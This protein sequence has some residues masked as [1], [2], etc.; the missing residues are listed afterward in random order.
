MSNNCGI[1]Q[2]TIILTREC[3]LRCN[4][5][6]VKDAGYRADDTVDYTDLKRIVDFCED[7][8]V[9]FIFFTGGEP[10]MYSRLVD[11]LQYIKEKKRP[12]TTAVATNG[13]LLQD[14]EL[15]RRLVESGLSY[16]DVSMKG[17]DEQDWYRT[18]G[19]AGHAAQ[20][21]AIRNLSALPLEFTCS[22]VITPENVHTF[23]DAVRLS[24]D[25]GA[26]QFSFTFA[27]DNND[28]EEQDEA[29]LEK[30]DPFALVEAFVAQIHRLNAITTNWWIEYS[31]PM[32]AYTDEQVT[33]LQGKLATPCQIHMKNAVTFDP[34]MDMLP[35]DMYIGEKI[36]RLGRDFSSYWEF[37]KW[38]QAA[39]YLSVMEALRRLPFDGCASCRY[40]KACYGGC[41]VLRKNYS[42]EALKAFREKH[43]KRKRLP[44]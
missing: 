43:E 12:M 37:Q 44:S 16:I 42:I 30:H 32:C 34:N 40:L 25:N 31:F 35:C 4:F 1:K 41:P 13:V 9:R 10:L 20:L 3:N 11:I 29:Y 19:H 39:P 27:I 8:K 26:K 17:K 38:T 36:G 6:Y 33:A 14:S 7:A 23:C 15:C 24:Y 18:V 5:C 22:M 28:S 2:C 21:Q